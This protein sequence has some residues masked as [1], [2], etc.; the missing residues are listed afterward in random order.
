MG[1]NKKPEQSAVDWLVEKLNQCEPFYSGINVPS[2]HVNNLIEEAR[3]MF[4]EQIVSTWNDYEKNKFGRLYRG[5]ENTIANG[6]DYF[7]ERFQ[8]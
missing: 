3:K 2:N 1:Q 8:K 7:M 5:T 6:R 4:E